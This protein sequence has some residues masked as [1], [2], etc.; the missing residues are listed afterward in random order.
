[1]IEKS[2]SIDNVFVWAL[3]MGHFL[4]PLKYQH[5]VLF[6]G[7]FGAL[8]LRAIFIFAGVALIEKFDWILYVFG[9]F[10]LYTAGKLM[11]GDD[12][13]ADPADSKFFK[14]VNKIVPSTD[15]Y[16]GQKLFTSA[17]PSAVRPRCWPC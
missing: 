12:E 10:L 5:R 11:F 16:D 4:V 6:W 9:A 3:I 7:I 8:M 15:E 1:L 13:H 2:L 17:M 14:A